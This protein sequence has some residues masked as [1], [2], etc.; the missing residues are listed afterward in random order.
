MLLLILCSHF[1]VLQAAMFGIGVPGSF[2]FD[3]SGNTAAA[4]ARADLTVPLN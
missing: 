1:T 3:L 2:N 4:S